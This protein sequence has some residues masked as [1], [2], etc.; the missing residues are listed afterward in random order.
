[1]PHAE[2]V[3][4]VIIVD[5][6]WT[7]K[8]QIKLIPGSRW[9][10][11]VK[12]WS[13]PLTWA[14]CLQLR[15]VFGAFLTVGSELNAWS[16]RE[17]A[18]R[19]QPATALRELLDPG[20]DVDIGKLLPFQYV[21]SRFMNVA[22]SSLLGDDT[23]LGKTVQALDALGVG[24]GLPALVICPNGVKLDWAEQTLRWLPGAVPFVVSGG[25]VTRR[26][27]IESARGITNALLIINIEAVRMFSRLAPY[28]STRLATCRVCNP[29]RGDEDLATSRCETHRKELN[30][31]GFRT[32]ILDEAHR[33]KEPSSKQTRAV[34]AVAHDPGVRTR[35]AMTGT[36]IANHVGD[37]WPVLHFIDPVEFPTKSKFV[38]R[39]GLQSWN[40]FGGLDIVGIN[41]HTRDEFYRIIDSRFRRTP[42]ALVL[43]QL[44]PKVRST[45]WVDMSPKQR[46]AYDELERR[47]FTTVDSG[48]LIAPNN[49]VKATRLLQLASSYAEVEWIPRKL[50]VLS[51]CEC[52]GR[53]LDEHDPLC[54]DAFELVVTLIEPSPKLDAL[55]E[56]LESLGD[57]Q[58]VIAAESRKLIELAAAR[59]LKRRDIP[60]GLITG[61]VGDYERQRAKNSFKSGD[62]R[63]ILM[64]IGAGGT[65]VDGLQVSDTLIVLQRSWKM[66]A[67][68]QLEGRVDR[69]GSEVHDSINII[70]IVTRDTIED[71]VLFP[72]LI[73]KFTRLDEITRDTARLTAAGIATPELFNLRDEESLIMSSELGVL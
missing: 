57:R 45:R 36:P 27:T 63:A 52:Y 38:D 51:T 71:R 24:D 19:V 34:W 32:V 10:S 40:A 43:T 46:R 37:L 59:L 9:N 60:F 64:T 15:G 22:G 49:L 11:D 29:G 1:M 4:D 28:G 21:G 56:E 61:A 30:G 3:D 14:A 68:V 35:W 67:N 13:V 7:E 25:A 39:Y 42:K 6:Q 26:K 47:L 66:L 72:R 23:G 33:I 5:T 12:R 54:P 31:F 48:I 2:R 65:G 53:A 44:P 17:L 50:T 20:E 16:H 8:E 69:I 73:E 58:V 62:L 41:P 55:E 18:Q 70:D